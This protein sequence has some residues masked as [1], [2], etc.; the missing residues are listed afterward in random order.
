M[1]KQQLIDQIKIKRSFL[2]IG[3]DVDLEKIP[4]HLLV[5]KDPIFEF[6]KRIIDAT[7]HL[8]VAYKPN[9]AFYEAYGIKGWKSLEKTIHYINKNYPEIFT[10]ADAKRG[11]I[12]NTSTRYAKAFFDDLNF[13]SVTVA[14]YMG[15]DSVEPFLAFADKFTILLALTSNKGGLDF[16]ILKDENGTTLYEKVL[17]ESQSWKNSERLMYVVG[18]TRPDYFKKIRK[19]IPNNF[20]LVPGVGAQGGD[21][22]EVCKYGLTDEIGLLINSSRGIIYASDNKD[23]VEKAKAKAMEMQKEMEQIILSGL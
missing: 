13:D 2:C 18:A 19:I 5:L 16:Q 23:F 3:L 22:M 4:K 17:K 1:N 12:G 11:D 8:T 6:N 10:I 7:H 15:S 14:P 21:L 9:T 20:I